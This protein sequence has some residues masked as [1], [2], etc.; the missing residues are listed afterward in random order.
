MQTR[1]FIKSFIVL[2]LLLN[3]LCGKK[4]TY[5]IEKTGILSLFEWGMSKKEIIEIIDEVDEYKLINNKIQFECELELRSKSSDSITIAIPFLYEFTFQ[6][7]RLVKIFRVVIS[8]SITHSDICYALNDAFVSLNEDEFGIPV[9]LNEETIED[10]HKLIKNVWQTDC[11]DLIMISSPDLGGISMFYCSKKWKGEYNEKDGITISDLW[12]G[13][14]EEDNA[15]EYKKVKETSKIPQDTTTHF[16]ISFEI[17]SEEE[18]NI[19]MGQK[20]PSKIHVLYDAV[21]GKRAPLRDEF[22]I[23]DFGKY[24]N[25]FFATMRLDDED[26][27]GKYKIKIFLNDHLVGMVTFDVVTSNE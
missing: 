15:S 3:V 2:L 9:V 1:Y 21:T 22:Y 18:V 25:T 7:D 4:P 10:D 5:P 13:I 19:K 23:T 24:R 12:F 16:A 14:I 26:P 27:L 20:M 17:D 6:G 11:T 8:E